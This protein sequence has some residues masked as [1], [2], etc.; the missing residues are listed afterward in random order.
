MSISIGHFENWANQAIATGKNGVNLAARVR[1]GQNDGQVRVGPVRPEALVVVNRLTS[2]TQEYKTANW[3]ARKAILDMIRA[4]LG[5]TADTSIDQFPSGVKDAMK[6]GAFKRLFF[7]GDWEQANGRPLTARRIRAIVNAVKAEKAARAEK[8]VTDL[9]AVSR[10]VKGVVNGDEAL[11]QALRNNPEGAAQ[12]CKALR[13]DKDARDLFVQNQAFR[14]RILANL[15][16]GCK[17]PLPTGTF[18]VPLGRQS[19]NSIQKGLN[20]VLQETNPADFEN[21]LTQC[22]KDL[23]RKGIVITWTLQGETNTICASTENDCKYLLKALMLA[24]GISDANK[25][26]FLSILQQGVAKETFASSEFTGGLSLPKGVAGGG[27]NNNSAMV[28]NFSKTDDGTLKCKMDTEFSLTSLGGSDYG[29]E[30]SGKGMMCYV[31]KKGNGAT[32][33]VGVNFDLGTPEEFNVA[34]IEAK[35][36]TVQFSNLRHDVDAYD[37]IP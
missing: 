34:N 5:Y 4:Q 3:N 26:K 37:D 21:M 9:L 2:G 14:K 29:V 17:Y 20:K 30:D 24:F 35:E 16:N 25:A 28:V 23:A 10:G 13:D 12:L 1:D 8:P 18:S 15:R 27:V 22:G 33:K 6:M 32:M 11:K 31:N 19:L 36:P 7:S